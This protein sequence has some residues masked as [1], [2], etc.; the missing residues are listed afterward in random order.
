MAPK[1]T[2]L[3]ERYSVYRI[4]VSHLECL[5][6]LNDGPCPCVSSSPPDDTKIGEIDK[7]GSTNYACPHGHLPSSC[8]MHITNFIKTHLAKIWHTWKDN[9]DKSKYCIYM[10]CFCR[11]SWLKSLMAKVSVILLWR[12]TWTCPFRISMWQNLKLKH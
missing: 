10:L 6:D 7:E 8:T 1:W 12:Q 9:P 4:Y 3:A 2:K 11:L 5:Q